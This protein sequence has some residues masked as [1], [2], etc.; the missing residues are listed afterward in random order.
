[1]NRNLKNYLPHIIAI[2]LFVGLAM[3]YMAPSIFEDKALLQGDVM[4]SAAWGKDLKDYHK[5][6]GDYAFWS[7]TM[8]GGMPA[9]Y[10]FMPPFFNIFSFIHQAI[11]VLLPGN[12]AVI[13][14]FLIGFYIFMLSIGCKPWLSAVGAIAYTFATFNLIS[15]GAGHVNKCL[16]MATMAPVIGGII[17]CYRKRY[18][19]GTIVTLLFTGL[20]VYW[21]HQQISYYLLII[22]L[23]LAIVYLIYA[24]KEHTLKD[25]FKSS[26]ILIVVAI[27]A[28]APDLGRLISTADYT[29]ET[30]RG[31]AV[32]QNNA[33]G[34]K[35][36]TG[37]EIDY[38]YMWSYGK[39]ETMTLLIPNF[40]GSNTHYD[41]GTNSE[42]Y[43]VLSQNGYGAQQAAQYSKYAA[44]YWGDQP[45]TD[46]PVYVGAIICFLFVL[47]L[48]IVKG[49]EKWW[50]LAAT[51]VSIILS[52]GR[53]AGINE[54]LFY[55][56]PL[57]N[58]F[59][60]PSMALVI[61]EV[62]MV[63]LAIL[64][65]KT[66]FDNKENRDNIKPLYISA[67]IVGGLCLIY[68]LIGGSLMSFTGHLD[69]RYK[70]FPQL[71]DALI[72]DRKQMLSS[73][74]WR[75][76]FFITLSAGT[77]WFYIKKPFKLSYVIAIVGILILTDLWTVD[78][79]FLNYESFIPKKN[80]QEFIASEADKQILQDKDP[81]YRVFNLTGSPF[82]ES[83]TSY[84][85]QSI[86]G[87]SPVKLRRYQDIIDYHFTGGI[88][89]NVLNML[90]TRYFIVSAQQ[91]PQVQRNAAALGNA[92][93]VNEIQ[94]VNSPD[95]EIV[96]VKDFNPSQKAVIDV[97][98][99]D[100]LPNWE[101]LQH[102]EDSSAVIT[103][104]DYANPGYL[105]YES[106]STQPHLA[107]FSEVY[108]K[109]WHA[110]ID[111]EEVPLVRVNYILR[112]LEIPAGNHTIEFK[113]ID[114]VYQSGAKISM[115]SSIVV[116]FV[117][118]G[119]FGYAIRSGMKKREEE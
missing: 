109:T 95:E 24:I 58:K 44:T 66:I 51:I 65:V 86:G 76:F 104:T 4:S 119:L 82:Q 23:I 6:T 64:A 62:T 94:W 98:W 99:K 31:G 42:F 79:R 15:L 7:N 115:A 72:A 118:L 27:L 88:N 108:Y 20:N 10:T 81:D 55:H 113:C 17:L 8:F 93:F 46:G 92:W 103:L 96:A 59:R 54:F 30:M 84:F 70:D 47:G 74:A 39:A 14:L 114:E 60:T 38:A 80:T 29:K 68:A 11:I 100:K 41:V 56:L 40:Y 117:L 102:P 89:M 19:W 1:M 112:G 48:I 91:G 97:T 52:W 83:Q 106:H 85:H 87:Y 67:G 73:D 28:V 5:E 116:G 90:N 18:V 53:N 2:L 71:V 22:I 3:A 78:K 13:F 12:M 9:N 43:K 50:L 45:M 101:R 111:G 105:I 21:S 37:L 33:K 61:A 57:Y 49:P 26:A 25:Y 75:S 63:T 36:S 69:E 77:L 32:L 110:Y 35:E 34:E 107:V 16:V